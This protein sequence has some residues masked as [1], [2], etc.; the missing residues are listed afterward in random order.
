VPTVSTREA[1]AALGVS[2]QAV[3]QAIARGALAAARQGRAY[4]IRRDEL[5]RY[6]QRR[7]KQD[8][9]QPRSAIVVLPA[10]NLE[11]F[12]P[13]PATRFVGREAELAAL[14]ARLVDPEERVVTVTG[15]GGVGKTRL[16]LA[17]A[18]ATR[19][20]FPDGVHFV[21]LASVTRP[22]MVVRAVTQSMGLR[23][24]PG[25][26]QR[27]QLALSLQG[28]RALLVL[29]NFEQIL[30]A[31]P[32]VAWIVAR[33]PETTVLITSRA[34]LRIGGERV[35]PIPP[36]SLAGD[37]VDGAALLAS[38]AGRLF[39]ARAQEQDPAFV[40]DDAS[41]P[42]I[43]DICARLD[44]LPLAI[45]LAAAQTRALSVDQLRQRLERRLPILTRGARD[46]PAR[47]QTM[48]AAIAWSY[49]LLG[50]A[51]QRLFR[52][53]AVFTGSC[54]LDAAEAIASRAAEGS[55]SRGERA[56]SF[57]TPRLL[58]SSTPLDLLASLVDQ[59]LV[60]RELGPA[61]EPRF[62]MLETIRE[63]GLAQL[64]AGESEAVRAAHARHYLQLA[65]ELRPLVET[66]ATQEPLDRLAVDDANVVQALAWLDEHGRTADV[67]SMTASLKT[68]WYAV[69]RL[70]EAADWIMRAQ[71][72]IGEASPGDRALL[73]I[74]HGEL[75]TVK[76]DTAGAERVF[77]EAEPRMREIG[78][79]FDLAMGLTAFG[80]ALIYGGKNA[81]AAHRLRE[82]LSCAEQIA[83]PRLRAAI[84]GDALHNL[85]ISARGQGNLDLAVTHC[86]SA[87]R[88]VRGHELPLAEHRVLV[89]MSGIAKDRGELARA[90]AGY[91][92]LLGQLSERGESLIIAAA[93]AGIAHAA[94]SWEQSRVALLLLGAA[95]ALRERGGVGMILPTEVSRESQDRA[96]LRGALGDPEFEATLAEGR[97]IPLAEALAVAVAVRPP[98]SD[99]FE[100]NPELRQ[101]LTRR[102]REILV[103]LSR[104]LTDQEI[105]AALF[106]SPR[107]VNWHVR[108]I[109][110]KLGAETRRDAV[111]QARIAGMLGAGSPAAA[112]Q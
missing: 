11:P 44:G 61:G 2:E 36:L 108:S 78:D 96:M 25:R 89:T 69:G 83:D 58:D 85:S 109:L 81:L 42:I 86:E 53:L 99:A 24:Q 95:D 31:A 73:M 87:L 29:D 3:R 23:E 9:A 19:D 18:T 26:D 14:V 94:A 38:D 106:L 104:A 52:R 27:T 50:A 49:D 54:T 17:A 74:A 101:P 13:T 30:A 62:R 39:V 56:G 51:E 65:R 112:D 8:P 55:S 45:E 1:A 32:D 16:A 90:V 103:M 67:A 97:V 34:A 10:P 105:A 15:P 76:G 46:A 79:P 71:T 80:A 60:V 7:L 66:L 93:L 43:A 12:L 100:A 98:G 28:K 82:A 111:A 4:R 84:A 40:V 6:A 21:D 41:A 47:L 107:T 64:E 63:F 75:Q 77:A 91:Q 88:R 22:P 20:R 5:T 92:A 57:S 102:E 68:Y 70:S 37:R 35:L 48:C 59:S 33:A 72:T 110:A